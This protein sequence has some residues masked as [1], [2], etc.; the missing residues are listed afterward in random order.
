MQKDRLKYVI[1]AVYPLA[2]LIY[3]A[4]LFISGLRE[5]ICLTAVL[6]AAILSA[7]I[8]KYVRIEHT[9]DVVFLVYIIYN[10]LSGIWCVYFGIPL[11]VY[12]GEVT[13]TLIPMG[14]FYAGRS[15]K[16]EDALRFYEWFILAVLFLGVLGVILNAV[17]PQFYLDY[18]VA[19][20]YISKADAETARVRMDSVV[21]SGALATL[22]CFSVCSS[23]FLIEDEH[24]SRRIRGIVY[25]VLSVV[26]AFMANQRASMASI[27][28]MLIFFNYTAFR[29]YKAAPVKY[30]IYEAAA[31]VL[32][33]GGI[34]VFAG[35]IFDKI[36]ARLVS[37]P[38]GFGERSEQWIAAVNN[39]CN[40]W[41]GDGLGSHG[42][43][44]VGY[45]PYIVADGGLVKIYAEMG[46]I[47]TSVIIFL[48]VLIYRKA[49]RN[50]KSVVPE[51]AIIT[52][53]ILISIGSNPLEFEICAP[54]AYFA[55]GRAVLKLTEDKG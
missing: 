35:G 16:D 19:M 41:L 50:L 22:L 2:S 46:L 4:A 24:K 45:Q 43:R 10:L 3:T 48:L 20:N 34:V 44:A 6:L 14:L 39:M 21:G 11:M 31:L 13:T 29:V 23:V 49:Y 9:E 27:I 32:A 7:V 17:A 28:I 30:L 53:A 52:C 15:M 40:I 33:I 18:S 12:V 1:F 26:F 37:I 55:L 38:Q 8:M 25:L 36:M 51:I 5:G 42:H 54:I 47:G